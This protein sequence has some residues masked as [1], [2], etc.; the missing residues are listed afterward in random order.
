MS[1]GDLSAQLK[2]TIIEQND[3]L[4][5]LQE[6]PETRSLNTDIY[7]SAPGHNRHETAVKHSVESVDS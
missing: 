6:Q 3:M 5:I 7:H 4:R 2:S 1:K